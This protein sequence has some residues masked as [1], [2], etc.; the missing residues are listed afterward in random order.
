VIVVSD[1]SP[2]ICLAHLDRLDLLS[3]LFDETLIPPAVAAEFDRF[4]DARFLGKL[5]A[6]RGVR[7]VRH[8]ILVDEM[9]G[10]SVARELGFEVIGTLALL[11]QAKRATLVSA[12]LPLV[13]RLRSELSFFVSKRIYA[14]IARESGEPDN[15]QS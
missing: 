15:A 8:G 3:V 12:V 13:D 4:R 6:S 10:R 14:Q 11:V 2:L 9:V 5:S 7:V 1:T